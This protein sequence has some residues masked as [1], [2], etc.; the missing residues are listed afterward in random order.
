MKT[1]LTKMI[2]SRTRL[3][4]IITC[5]GVSLAGAD[6]STPIAEKASAPSTTPIS[7]WGAET[8]PHGSICFLRLRG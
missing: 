8:I 4:S 2:G 3:D 5:D 6:K 1:P 7:N